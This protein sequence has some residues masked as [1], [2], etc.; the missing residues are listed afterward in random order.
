MRRCLEE[1]GGHQFETH[2]SDW[3]YQKNGVLYGEF[4]PMGTGVPLIED[5]KDWTHEDFEG[6]RK[7]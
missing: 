6:G 2:S 7:E 5:Y 3:T 1:H 4:G